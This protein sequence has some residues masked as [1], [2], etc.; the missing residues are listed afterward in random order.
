MLRHLVFADCATLCPDPH[1][2]DVFVAMA[3]GMYPFCVQE[4]REGLRLQ[5]RRVFG[6]NEPRDRPRRLADAV[7]ALEGLEGVRAYH[8]GLSDSNQELHV[9]PQSISVAWPIAASREDHLRVV[10][11]LLGWTLWDADA[12]WIALRRQC[13]GTPGP[14]PHVS[15]PRHLRLAQILDLVGERALAAPGA[16]MEQVLTTCREAAQRFASGQMETVTDPDT[17]ALTDVRHC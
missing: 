2:A 8:A 13:T 16:T 14:L 10:P 7:E 4:D 17:R 15:Q 3:Y 6:P 5:F 12:A 1:L 9:Q 11:E